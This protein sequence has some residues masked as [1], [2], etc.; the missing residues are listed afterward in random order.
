MSY[1]LDPISADCYPNTTTL[2]NKFDI[3]NDTQ[4]A[5]IEVVLVSVHAAEWESSPGRDDFS[6]RH[7]RAIHEYLFSE[8]YQW[9]GTIRTVNITKKGTRFCP[10]DNVELLA[11]RV[12]AGL[13]SQ[14]FLRDLS[15][16]AFIEAIVDF[17]CL[18]NYLHPFR[19]GNGRTQRLFISQLV[20]SAGYE[21]NFSDI[22]VD[23]LMVATIQAAQGVSDLLRKVFDEAVR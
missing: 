15:R 17:Y 4:L 9:A 3:R 22:D 14:N 20:R 2:I 21:F 18:T 10:A 12:F 1:G 8:L 7:Y 19:E 11:E 16:D 5:E 23:L 13:K 6:F